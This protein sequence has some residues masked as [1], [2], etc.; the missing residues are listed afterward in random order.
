MHWHRAL[1]YAATGSTIGHELSHNYD[2]TG[3]LFNE[4]GNVAQ[5]WTNESYEEFTK[6]TDCLVNYYN[7]M[8]IV[9]HDQQVCIVTIVERYKGSRNAT[10]LNT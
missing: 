1:D 2:N 8:T 5:W 10:D 6:R 9:S 3:R 4:L 7:G